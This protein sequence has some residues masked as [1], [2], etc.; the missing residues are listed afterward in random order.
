MILLMQSTAVQQERGPMVVVNILAPYLEVLADFFQ[1]GV[2][3]DVL[4]C[5]NEL[6]QWNRPHG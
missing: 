3:P 1:L 5:T 4:T 2:S 6:Q